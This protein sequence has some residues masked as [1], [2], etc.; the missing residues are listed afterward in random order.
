M[1]F[2]KA[3]VAFLLVYVQVVSLLA[4][5][6]AL[7][8]LRSLKRQVSSAAED[9]DSKSRDSKSLIM[10]MD[11][12]Q[13]ATQFSYTEI[14][15]EHPSQLSEFLDREETRKTDILLSTDTPE[16]YQAV[17][18]TV[19][20]NQKHSDRMFRF[21]PIGK[22]AS[23]KESL[24]SGWAT[25][26][27]NVKDTFRYDKLGLSI[28]VITT[29][30]D[31][32]IWIHSASMDV[33]QKSA[34]V[35]MNVVFAAAFALDRDLWSRM[36]VPLRHRIMKTLDKISGKMTGNTDA[37]AVY[38]RKVIASQFLANLSYS[39]GFQ[40]LRASIMSYHDLATTVMTSNFWLMSLKV[41][42][43]TTM[44]SFAWGELM[45][46]ANAEKHPVAKNA[47]KRLSDVRNIVMSQLASMGMVLQ[48]GTYG[49]TPII[50][51]VTSGT[52][53]LIALMK[54]NKVIQWLENSKVAN[55]LFRN[56]RQLE[57]LVNDAASVVQDKLEPK[58]RASQ[59][60]SERAEPRGATVGMCQALFN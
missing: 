36:T 8:Y 46:A 47:L 9:L 3:T 57:N 17:A 6:Q 14:P 37:E 24:S 60:A 20:K 52:I 1:K 22:L 34:M 33:Y 51:I 49:Y 27:K 31:S 50:A 58:A 16:I 42:A 35:M 18:E 10:N 48:P 45:A 39:V 43:I 23:V 2:Y 54:S 29:S 38:A 30:F 32:F 28:V 59:L 5:P 40:L 7:P 12:P 44:A 56:Q 25:Y 55:I 21:M 26:S 4:A 41:A 53:G 19:A 15:L 11:G 13:G